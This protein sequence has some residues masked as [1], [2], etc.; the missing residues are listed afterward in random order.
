MVGADF[1][2]KPK[3]AAGEGKPA[4]ER[5]VGAAVVVCYGLD[6]RSADTVVAKLGKRQGHAL[7]RTAVMVVEHM[8]RQVAR[9]RQFIGGFDPVAE[10]ER[11][12][13]KDFVKRGFKLGLASIL[14][15]PLVLPQ[16]RLF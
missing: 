16:D 12:N 11:G 3:M 15:A 9:N 8:G 14:Q 10:P 13:A 6:N 2:T 4:D 7:R 1:E 5:P